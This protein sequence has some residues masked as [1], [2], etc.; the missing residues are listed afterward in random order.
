[1]KFLRNNYY[2][3]RNYFSKEKN[4]E[5]LNAFIISG[6]NHV[7][8]RIT[9]IS[10]NGNHIEAELKD[11]EKF[12]KAE[13][14]FQEEE[15]AGK[16]AFKI[17]EKTYLVQY[18]DLGDCTIPSSWG[19]Y[20]FGM[21][22]NGEVACDCYLE[23]CWWDEFFEC[24]FD[25]YEVQEGEVERETFE[26]A[27]RDKYK[28]KAMNMLRKQLIKD[29]GEDFWVHTEMYYGSPSCYHIN[30]DNFYINYDEA[31]FTICFDK[32]WFAEWC[33]NNRESFANRP[34]KL[35]HPMSLQSALLT[36]EPE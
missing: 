31:F 30:L 24:E 21:L 8:G 4:I 33:S 32:R 28:K 11:R 27:W 23:D 36:V 18:V 16:R 14:F 6:F 15:P 3:L 26:T 9:N 17:A 34:L 7:T 2:E 5:A 19:G 25:I 22:G 1:M 10:G 20:D 29:F 13:I 35:E 12:A